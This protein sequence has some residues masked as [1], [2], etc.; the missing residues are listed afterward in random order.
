[1]SKEERRREFAARAAQLELFRRVQTSHP[2]PNVP[3]DPNSVNNPIPLAS[4]SGWN[5]NLD[6]VCDEIQF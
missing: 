5:T 2:L 6:Q 1:M 4:A 3:T